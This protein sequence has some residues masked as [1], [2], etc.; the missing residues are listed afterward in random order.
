M[1]NAQKAIMIGV[2][3]FITIIVIAAVM[4]IT[5]MG[6]DLLNSGTNQLGGVTSSLEYQV[7]Q[8]YDGTIMSR[9]QVIAAFKSLITNESVDTGYQLKNGSGYGPEV[10]CTS[11]PNINT[12][13]N[14]VTASSKFKG[15]VTETT[16]GKTYKVIFQQ[17]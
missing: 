5:G 16:G 11:M 4:L 12:F 7:V 1:D 8:P 15:V 14:S 3:L 9:E 2:G 10:S 13:K 17:Q 6:Q